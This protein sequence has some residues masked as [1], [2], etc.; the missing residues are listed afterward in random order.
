MFDEERERGT[1]LDEDRGGV[2][3]PVFDK[4]TD[5]KLMMLLLFF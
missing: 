1:L 3:R 5:E 2:D 4:S